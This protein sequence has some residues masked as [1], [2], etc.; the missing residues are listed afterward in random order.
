[1]TSM[2]GPLSDDVAAIAQLDVVPKILETVCCATGLGF[3]AVARV[4]EDRWIACAVRD[5]I[6]FGLEPGGEL[7][8]KTTICDEIRASG[9]LV[10]ID[11]VAEDD[12]FRDHPTPRK[13]GFQSYISVP[14]RLVDG[15]FFGTLCAID[16]KPGRV[17]APETIS[18]FELFANLIAVHLDA[19]ERLQVSETA[20]LDQRQSVELKDQLIAVLGHDLGN[21][22]AAIQMGTMLL[23]ARGLDEEALRVVSLIDSTTAR[24]SGLIANVLD[25]AR[26]RL[27]G[28]LPVDLA[29]DSE[30][31]TL[32]D[33]VISEMRAAHP[34][35]I[36]EAAYALRQPVIC[37]R[38]RIGQ[39]L[40][41]LIGNAL[42]HGDTA[43]PVWVRGDSD[44]T[45]LE[46][47]V[48]NRGNPIPKGA[49]ERLFQPFVRGASIHQ[50]GLGLGLY[51][52]A[53]IARA[54]SG[55]LDVVST[56]EET[57]FTLRI[58]SAAM[59]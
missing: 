54:H 35:R 24:M 58:P 33:Q 14:I 7:E 52:S 46:L 2:H 12:L 43:S 3:S 27:G 9:C 42:T 41:N 26:G 22:L 4:T 55:S 56:P 37:D 32:F 30:L 40:S 53:E 44:E 25:F 59:S 38:S 5:E 13:Y 15:R 50:G 47:S 57:R 18:M 6:G 23:R 16:P 1:M 11:H 48:V 49:Q 34:G 17:K 28:G 19:H 45:G 10:A 31:R 39:V 21:P 20:L 51:I 36:I 29:A 8:V